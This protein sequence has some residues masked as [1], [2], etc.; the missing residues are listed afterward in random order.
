[1]AKGPTGDGET[2]GAGTETTPERY[3]KTGEAA[4]TRPDSASKRPDSTR[5]AAGETAKIKAIRPI[6]AGRAA[7]KGSADPPPGTGAVRKG[8]EQRVGWNNSCHPSGLIQHRVPG[9]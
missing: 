8:S 9:F 5:K 4:G 6:G 1:M 2:A 7:G 3:A